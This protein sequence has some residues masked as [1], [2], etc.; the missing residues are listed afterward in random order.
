MLSLRDGKRLGSARQWPERG[1]GNLRATCPPPV[2]SVFLTPRTSSPSYLPAT[3]CR[4]QPQAG[5]SL[6]PGFSRPSSPG[7]ALTTMRSGPRARPGCGRPASLPLSSAGKI[8]FIVSVV[9]GRCAGLCAV[10]ESSGMHPINLRGIKEGYKRQR[11]PHPRGPSLPGSIS[12]DTPWGLCSGD[13]I[14]TGSNLGRGWGAGASELEGRVAKPSPAQHSWPEPDE[15]PG[16]LP[17][18]WASTSRQTL[19]NKGFAARCTRPRTAWVDGVKLSGAAAWPWA[20]V[21]PEAP[22]SPPSL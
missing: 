7:L 6:L 2:P 14:K 11:V 1:L 21:D 16:Y 3:S 19:E 8:S 17:R 12:S 5:G 13:E 9:C 15:N 18:P 4:A 22:L 20:N 10:N